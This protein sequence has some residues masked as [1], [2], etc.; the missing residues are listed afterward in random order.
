LN[1]GRPDFDRTHTLN[2][3]AV[4]E[5]PFGK[6]KRFLNQ[7]GWVDKVFGG[8]QLSSIVNLS[9]GPPLSITDP[10]AT[11]AVLAGQFG[12]QTAMSTLTTNEIKDLTGV[13]K[14]PNG[15]YFFNPKILFATANPLPGTGLPVLQGI[16]LTQPLPAGYTLGTVRAAS[17]ISGTPF[18]GQVFFFNNAGQTGN[19]PR[20]FINGLPYLNWDA[21]LSKNI[22][23]TETTRLQIRF[24]AF[25]VLNRQ[26]P[27]YNANTDINSDSFGRVTTFT[28]GRIFQ[29]G[30]RFDF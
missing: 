25:N 9:S 10:R 1:Y 17:A 7:G 19:L 23:F 14:T 12:G 22:R 6:G 5:L 28:T 4:Y 27:Q 26:V 13:F 29:F 18:A 11:A 3:N 2:A 8:F 15:I 20:N 21:G 30:A 16:D 24:E